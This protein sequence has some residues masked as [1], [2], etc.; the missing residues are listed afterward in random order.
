MSLVVREIVSLAFWM[1]VVVVAAGVV[2]WLA[3]YMLD[4]GVGPASSNA[5][6]ARQVVGA[7]ILLLCTI[8]VRGSAIETWDR[9][10]LIERVDRWICCGGNL[11]GTAAIVA[12]LAW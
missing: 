10:T 9:E 11:V 1:S 2:G 8:Y 4:K 6:A 5:V 3:G 7:A 12:S